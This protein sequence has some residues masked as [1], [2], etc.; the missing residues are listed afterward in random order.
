MQIPHADKKGEG[1]KA[2]LPFNT[3]E[4]VYIVKL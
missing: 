4:H 1:R 2:Y 3:K